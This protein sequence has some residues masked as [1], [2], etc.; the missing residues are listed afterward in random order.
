M[1]ITTRN[2][3]PRA[4]FVERYSGNG[5][6]LGLARSGTDDHV[7]TVSISANMGNYDETAYQITFS[8]HDDPDQ[9]DTLIEWLTQ[10]RATQKR[11]GI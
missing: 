10:L 2:P 7:T 9:L 8:A 1:R 4:R 5:R 11:N 3:N 6:P